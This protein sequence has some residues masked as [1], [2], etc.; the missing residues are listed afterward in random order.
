MSSTRTAPRAATINKV[1]SASNAHHTNGSANTYDVNDS[2]SEGIYRNPRFVHAVTVGLL[3]QPVIIQTTE[4]ERFH[5]VL[6]TISPNGDVLLS[7]AHRLD[8]NNN[9]IM[10]LSTSLIDLLDTVESSAQFLDLNKRIISSSNIVEI[11]ASDIDL[12]GNGKCK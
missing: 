2:T 9:D 12:A 3:G 8:N 11:I 6:E 1:S 5:G 10:G 7:V 4:R